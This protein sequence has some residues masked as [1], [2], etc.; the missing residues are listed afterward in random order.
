MNKSGDIGNCFTEM[1]IL[2]LNCVNPPPTWSTL[3]NALKQ[4]AVNFQQLAEQIEKMHRDKDISAEV[5]KLSFPHIKKVI[6]D[7]NAREKFEYRLRMESKAIIMQFRILRNKFFDSIERQKITAKKLVKYLK[8]EIAEAL[9]QK[10]ITTKPITVDDVEEFIENNTSFYDY[11]LIQYMIE[12]IGTDKD[13][14]QLKHYEEA[15]SAYAERRV[16]ECPSIFNTSDSDT[17]SELHVKLDSTYDECKL[18]ELKDFQY[19]LCSVL[20]ISVHL[21]HLKSIEKGC[22]LLTF[23]IPHHVQEAIFPLSIEQE[24][25]LLE[26][27]VHKFTCGHYQFPRTDNQV[28]NLNQNYM[29]T[30]DC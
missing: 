25:A 2:W 10:T 16:Y 30:S 14:D 28:S 7:G 24:T 23:F 26:L 27:R 21:C 20:R 11:Q 18:E 3:V 12:V 17:K 8:E 6:T 5:A 19:R 29:N 15:F 4:P 1:L 22:F 13:K 9:Q